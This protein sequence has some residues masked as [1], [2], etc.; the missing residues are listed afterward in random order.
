MTHF[1]NPRRKDL[2]GKKNVATFR[3]VHHHN[4]NNAG[5]EQISVSLEDSLKP[6]AIVVLSLARHQIFFPDIV[7]AS[8]G[9]MIALE[10]VVA[11]GAHCGAL[12]SLELNTRL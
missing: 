1:V 5:K 10:H 8:I 11:G 3:N 4:Q 7:G 6:W 9:K 12:L 2:E